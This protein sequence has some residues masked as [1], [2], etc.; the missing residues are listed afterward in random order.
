MLAHINALTAIFA[1]T[2]GGVILLIVVLLGTS[3]LTP[4]AQGFFFAFLSFGSLIQV[5]DFGLSYAILQKASHFNYASDGKLYKFESLARIWG[6]VIAIISTILVGVF[7]F[8]SFSMWEATPGLENVNW[9]LAWAIGLLGLFV[10][11]CLSPVVSLLE[12]SGKIVTAWRLRMLQEWIGGILFLIAINL[13]LDLFSI[14]IYWIGRS[15]VVLPLIFKKVY[16]VDGV[17]QTG[18]LP[19]FMWRYEIWPFQWR[20]GLSNLSGYLIFRATTIVLLSEQGPILAGKYG[21]ALAMMNMMLSVTTSWPISQAARL[22]QLISGNLTLAAT[23]LA[24]FTLKYSTLF[25]VCSTIAVWGVFAFAQNIH[26]DISDRITD[27]GTL[28]LIL[29]TGV[30]HHIVACQAVLLRAQVR[31]PLLKITVIGGVVNIISAFL[32]SR[33]G[34]LFD[35]AL[36]GLLLGL[37]GLGV[38]TRLYFIQCKSW[39]KNIIFNFI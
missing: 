13:G 24:N 9:K 12:G 36:S 2:S 29:C 28:A 22:G 6:L 30:I 20:I 39:K 14:A 4:S 26:L 38:S 11:Q 17:Q 8:M 32:A 31:E 5:G 35:V 15:I 37:L 25:A 10:G 23:D 33:Y 18:Y 1:T 27:L 19:K 21:F 7:G 16:P 34:S 3:L